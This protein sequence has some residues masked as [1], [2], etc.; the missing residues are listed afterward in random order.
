MGRRRNH[1]DIGKPGIAQKRL[2]TGRMISAGDQSHRRAGGGRITRRRR[3]T[4]KLADIVPVAVIGQAV[5]IKASGSPHPETCIQKNK[6]SAHAADLHHPPVEISGDATE[7]ELLRRGHEFIIILRREFQTQKPAVK[8]GCAPRFEPS[9]FGRAGHDTILDAALQPVYFFQRRPRIQALESLEML[10]VSGDRLGIASKDLLGINRTLRIQK[11]LKI[12]KSR[13]IFKTHSAPPG[14]IQQHAKM[15]ADRLL[16]PVARVQD[17]R[18]CSGD[19]TECP[20]H[21]G[22]ERQ[23]NACHVRFRTAALPDRPSIERKRATIRIRIFDTPK[24]KIDIRR[25][26]QI[27]GRLQPPAAEPGGGDPLPSDAIRRRL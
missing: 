3:Q 22:V 25:E 7:V 16:P 14:L 12:Q 17:L 27:F 13:K 4:Q 20:A 21:H 6:S 8:G 11:P 10:L 5:K 15:I 26:L 1:A 24:S 18:P 9:F 19:R 2:E 23:L